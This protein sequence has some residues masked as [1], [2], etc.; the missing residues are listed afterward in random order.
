[1][2]HRVKQKKKIIAFFPPFSFLSKNKLF[3]VHLRNA[4]MKYIHLY[5]I[6]NKVVSIVKQHVSFSLSR[7][8]VQEVPAGLT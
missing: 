2:F 3:K 6:Y 4:I 8:E 1:M 5:H 7:Q